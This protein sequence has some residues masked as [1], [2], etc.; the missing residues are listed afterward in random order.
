MYLIFAIA[1]LSSD[2]CNRV[3]LNPVL[4]QS[5]S[6]AE[7]APKY[8]LP[9]Y[10]VISLPYIFYS[11]CSWVLAK[12]T[13]TQ[14][15]ASKYNNKYWSVYWRRYSLWSAVLN[16]FGDHPYWANEWFNELK[17]C[18]WNGPKTHQANYAKR[19]IKSDANKD[20]KTLNNFY[21]YFLPYPSQAPSTQPLH[22][23]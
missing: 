3:N 7:I 1:Q 4:Q 10:N 12:K 20:I 11:H 16:D 13:A 19:T 22:F 17:Q 5:K 6:Q 14:F 18:L 2:F 15:I 23:S 21:T 8:K 9:Q